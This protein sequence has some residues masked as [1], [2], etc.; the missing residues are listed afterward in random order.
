MRMNKLLA[1]MIAAVLLSV[2]V[3]AGNGELR[4]ADQNAVEQ[5]IVN[6]VQSV[7]KQD[8]NGVENT[9]YSKGTVCILNTFTKKVED[10]TSDQFIDQVKNGTKG[11][12][13]RNVNVTSV[14]FDANTA[15]AKVEITDAKLKQSGYLTLINDNGAWKIVSGVFSL[16]KNQ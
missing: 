1:T 5:T 8:A 16:G 11:G 9:L 13:V 2:T 3:F 10:Y 4:K 7:D 6:Y 14:D 15:M 12:W